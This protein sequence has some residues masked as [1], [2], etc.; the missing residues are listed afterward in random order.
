MALISYS[1]A[2]D[3]SVAFARDVD[4]SY[5]IRLWYIMEDRRQVMNPILRT[6][7]NNSARYLPIEFCLTGKKPNLSLRLLVR[8]RFVLI[9]QARL[10]ASQT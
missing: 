4:F 2:R 8:G 10:P 9:E 6:D 5:E 1:I 3:D 7:C